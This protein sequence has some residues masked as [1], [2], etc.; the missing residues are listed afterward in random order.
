VFALVTVLHSSFE[1]RDGHYRSMEPGAS[2]TLERLAEPL[3]TM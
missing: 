1:N 3:Q 2:E